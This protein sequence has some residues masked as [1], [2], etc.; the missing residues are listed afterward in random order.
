MDRVMRA[1]ILIVGSLFWDE[2]DVRQEWRD[3]RLLLGEAV[4]VTVPIYY[5]RQASTR[6]NT[7]TMAFDRRRRRRGRALLV[8][9]S[10]PVG[11]VEDLQ[12]EARELWAAERRK[13]ELG[14]IGADWGCVGVAFHGRRAAA[15]ADGWRGFF[16]NNVT[17]PVW[18]VTEDG[19][20]GIAW[21]RGAGSTRA[22]FI[23][24]TATAPRGVGGVGAV[25]HA[26]VEQDAGEEK[27]FFNNVEHGIRTPDD[28]AIWRAMERGRTAWRAEEKYPRAVEILRGETVP[29]RRVPAAPG[30]GALC[31]GPARPEG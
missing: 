28:R 11:G 3:R 13:R 23:L 7:Y 18:P 6:G 22:D 30:E 15:L 24:T 17:E 12:A 16:R 21:P 19:V 31:G 26:W 9:C 4:P 5:G 25:A 1:A 14:G 10:T 29:R 20:L 27:Y 8:P 2:V